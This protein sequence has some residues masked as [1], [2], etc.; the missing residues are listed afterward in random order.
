[1]AR[2]VHY[3]RALGPLGSLN[4]STRLNPPARRVPFVLSD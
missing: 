3:G 1:M 2:L 4:Q